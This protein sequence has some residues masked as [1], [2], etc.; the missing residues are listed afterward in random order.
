MCQTAYTNTVTL[1]SLS[2]GSQLLI[3][4]LFQIFVSCRVVYVWWLTT[5]QERLRKIQEEM[6]RKKAEERRKR[7]EEERKRREEEEEKKK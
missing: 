3:E 4:A 6:E 5:L 1:P 2:G 7:E